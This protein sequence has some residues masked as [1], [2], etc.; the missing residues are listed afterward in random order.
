LSDAARRR[1]RREIKFMNNEA[2]WLQK[3]LFALQ[4]VEMVR[5]KIAELNGDD[6]P[7]PFVLEHESGELE[8]EVF[9]EAM[10]ARVQHLLKE[11]RERRKVVR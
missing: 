2:V 5:E 4:K 10:E 6:D 8:V 7:E 11:V 1:K 9:Q 3:A